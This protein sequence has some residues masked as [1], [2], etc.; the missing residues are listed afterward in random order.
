MI[1]IA[2]TIAGRASGTVTLRKTVHRP[3]PDMNADSSSDGSIERNDATMRRKTIGD[4]CSP[5]TQIIPQ[6]LK[7]SITARPKI[8]SR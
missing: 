8:G 1:R 5:S 3:A 7:T 6:M 4:S 2:A